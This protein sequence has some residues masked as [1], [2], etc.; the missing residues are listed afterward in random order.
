LTNL[1]EKVLAFKKGF[2]KNKMASSDPQKTEFQLEMLKKEFGT[3]Q[4]TFTPFHSALNERSKL[5]AQVYHAIKTIFDSRCLKLKIELK[6]IKNEIKEIKENA[7]QRKT[8]L[9]QARPQYTVEREQLKRRQNASSTYSNGTDNGNSI[10]EPTL[11]NPSTKTMASNVMMNR[12]DLSHEN[13]QLKEINRAF[14]KVM[15]NFQKMGEIVSLHD[16]MFSDIEM[17]TTAAQVNVEKGKKTLQMIY[18][19]V[20]SNRPFLLKIFAI[21]T[22]IAVL[23]ILL[24]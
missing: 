7:K 6:R 17:N 11:D 22:F 9:T 2:S 12:S 14:D 16:E 4:E 21:V 3:L 1:K 15:S 23:F 13:K 24:K 8:F 5:K 20:H 18:Q 19:D 10:S